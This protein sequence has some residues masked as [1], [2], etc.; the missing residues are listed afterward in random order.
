MNTGYVLV[1][2]VAVVLG[3]AFAAVAVTHIAPFTDDR[4][5]A[6]AVDATVTG[7][8]VQTGTNAEGQQIYYPAISYRYTYEGTE[9]TSDSVFPGDVNPVSDQSRA[10]ELVEEY[11]AGSEV[12]AYVN[13]EDPSRSYLVDEQMPLW[14][15]L[16]P[17]VGVLLVLYGFHSIRLGVQGVE[18]GPAGAFE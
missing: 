14:Y 7:S 1:G 18:H 8:E 17:V 9:F 16:G 4:A 5:D 3:L 6:V 12:T 10:R 11:A 2:V 13:V 15:W